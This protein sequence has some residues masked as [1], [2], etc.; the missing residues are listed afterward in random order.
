MYP[1]NPPKAPKN[2]T[3]TDYEAMTQSSETPQ[4]KTMHNVQT[5][6]SQLEP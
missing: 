3:T 2:L 4:Y 5:A 1:Q 6:K